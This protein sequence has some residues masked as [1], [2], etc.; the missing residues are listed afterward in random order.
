MPHRVSLRDGM[1][2]II[3]NG[4]RA[5]HRVERGLSA[6]NETIE[7]TRAGCL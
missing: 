5:R 6:R 4:N 7:F 3:Q 1:A 2:R